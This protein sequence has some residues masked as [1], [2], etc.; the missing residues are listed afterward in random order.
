MICNIA[1]V[2][3]I[4]NVDTFEHL[5]RHFNPQNQRFLNTDD[6]VKDAI[7]YATRTI[8]PSFTDRMMNELGPGNDCEGHMRM[9]VFQTVSDTSV[10]VTL[11]HVDG[12]LNDLAQ[13]TS[14]DVS[15]NGNNNLSSEIN[16]TQ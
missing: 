2:V 3:T 7:D 9:S 5:T 1:H 8:L 13:I 6:Y 16:C 4:S 11:S 14:F 12:I 15:S 10:N